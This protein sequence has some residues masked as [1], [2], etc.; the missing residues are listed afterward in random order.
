MMLDLSRRL[1]LTASASLVMASLTASGASWAQ[2]T[3]APAQPA[4][5]PAPPA[6]TAPAPAPAAPAPASP[7]PAPAAPVAAE[8]AP[9]PVAPP[10]VIVL[11]AD[12]DGLLAEVKSGN[13]TRMVGLKKGDNRVEV[14]AGS[15]QITVKT[16]DGRTVT[17]Q[18]V[19]TAAEAVR[20][21]VVSLGRVVVQ[22][23]A[24]ADVE[25]DGKEVQ[26]DKGVYS[27]EAAPGAHTLLVQRA[28]H[29]GQKGAIDVAM[30]KTTTVP[31]TFQSWDA[32]G[33]KTW[34]WVAMIG[35]GALIATAVTIN[36]VS[37]YDELGGDVSRW[38]LFGLGTAGFVGGTVLLK[39]AMDEA[40]PV[41]DTRF[42][43][44]VGRTQGGAMA[45][46]G[47]KF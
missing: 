10:A 7:A 35:G 12:A 42:N 17:D 38:T 2:T 47:W 24:D 11:V 15:V 41:Q 37:T 25:L 33:K 13:E 45:T 6:A 21:A 30:G 43:V 3:A 34:A 19:Q 40:A 1:R 31:V 9:Q 4:T 16:S 29:Y 22:V 32:G 26:A 39:H 5:P 20:V 23:P 8:A 36:A 27:F 14:A 44:Q 28:G 46:V 18:T